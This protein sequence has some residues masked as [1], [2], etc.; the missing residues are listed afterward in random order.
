MKRAS[1]IVR[2]LGRIVAVARVE[3]L[4]LLHDRTSLSLILVVPAL[5]MLLFGY[6]VNLNPRHITA[7]ASQAVFVVDGQRAAVQTALDDLMGHLSKHGL[8]P[9]TAA[10]VNHSSQPD[11]ADCTPFAHLK[12]HVAFEEVTAGNF[13][14][15]Y[16]AARGAVRT[17][18]MR[19]PGVRRVLDAMPLPS[20]RTGPCEFDLVRPA[21]VEIDAP[22]PDNKKD[23]V[24]RYVSKASAAR[25]HFGRA[26]RQRLYQAARA[27]RSDAETAFC[28]D[29]QET[30]AAPRPLSRGLE[31]PVSARRKIAVFSADGD[32]F[33]GL[34]TD[35]I[36][37]LGAE[38]GLACMTIALRRMNGLLTGIARDL[39]AMSADADENLA[40]AAA[41]I[42]GEGDDRASATK[43]QRD[44]GVTRLHRFETLLFGG[45]D[46]VFVVPCWLAWWLALRFFDATKDWRVEPAVVD[47]AVALCPDFVPKGFDEGVRLWDVRWKE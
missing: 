22:D 10:A 44:L 47:E 20:G 33:G 31:L 8:D 9:A 2:H 21:Q 27:G 36:A 15:A 26:L 1:G 14:A 18:Q 34:R 11:L 5:Q 7:G 41:A 28:D 30:I 40:M 38:A 24:K 46:I 25:W 13:E 42:L 19:D 23:S 16:H 32:G 45:E 12:F 4:R 17:A 3:L 37:A 6:A 35:L 39:F 29:F 43:A